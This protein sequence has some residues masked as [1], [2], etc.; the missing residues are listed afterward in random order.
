ME[1]YKNPLG[2]PNNICYKWALDLGLKRGGDTI[3]YTG[4]LYQLMSYAESL[5]RLYERLG[6][7]GRNAAQMLIKISERALAW[8]I[9]RFIALDNDVYSYSVRSLRGVVEILRRSGVEFG[10]LYEGDIY[11]GIYLYELGLEEDF[12]RH[13]QTVYNI[14]RSAGVKKVITVDPHT[15]YVLKEI[16]PRY[17]DSYQLEVFHYLEVIRDAV[18][19]NMKKANMK[20]DSF[21]R[22]RNPPVIHDSCY[23]M[24]KLGLYKVVRRSLNNIRYIEPRRTGVNTLC[25]GGPIEGISPGLALKVAVKRA[26]ELA[27]TGSQRVIVMCPICYV[28]LKRAFARLRYE[29]AIT[30][31]S[32]EILNATY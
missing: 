6:R 9:A 20:K 14:F 22:Y 7:F 23:M 15:T 24:R 18:G 19:A 13:A 4:C 2:A 27:S 8:L 3:L 28:N 17:I 12:A 1:R 16:Y 10:Y 31:I 21:H 5:V 32:E 30:D 29:I 26:E 11:S 25:C